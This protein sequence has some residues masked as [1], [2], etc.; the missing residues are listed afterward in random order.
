RQL[1][2]LLVGIEKGRDRLVAVDL[3][4]ADRGR[5]VLGVGRGQGGQDCR[6]RGGAQQGQGS[7][8]GDGCVT[9]QW[10]KKKRPRDAQG[11]ITI[12]KTS[13]ITS[14]WFLCSRH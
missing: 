12:P 2:A 11:R 7:E 3:A 10:T 4:D 5:I 14:A 8:H 1:P 9:R 6:E 13:W